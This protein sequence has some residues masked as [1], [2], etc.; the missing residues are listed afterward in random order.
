MDY[1]ILV[2]SSDCIA[3]IHA[4]TTN[5][6]EKHDYALTIAKLH[7]AT[8]KIVEDKEVIMSE[9]DDVRFYLTEM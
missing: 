9:V 6:R 5:I 8:V 3:V 2:M 1:I 7:N 4:D